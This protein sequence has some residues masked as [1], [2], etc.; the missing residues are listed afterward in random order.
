MI[1]IHAFLDDE[2]LNSYWADGLIISTA[3]GSTGYSLS[4]GGPIMVPGT[5]NFIISPIA[6][7]N[8][9]V[10]P[11]V[12]SDKNVIKLKVEDRDELAL[13]AL[14]SRS[15]AIDPSLELTIKKADFKINLIKLRDQS[16]ISTI[17][18]KLMWG[19]DKRN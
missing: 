19:K 15:R 7:H 8:L 6:P 2:F 4:C 10:R 14:D 18:E 5:D 17:R 13:V 9:N 3:T 1:R 16:F 11:V 12:I